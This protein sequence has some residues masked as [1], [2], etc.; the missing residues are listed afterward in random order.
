MSF[1]F[2]PFLIAQ[3]IL[4]AGIRKVLRTRVLIILGVSL[5]CQTYSDLATEHSEVLLEAPYRPGHL[6]NSV[7]LTVDLTKG[8][9]DEAIARKDSI[10]VAYRKFYNFLFN[11]LITDA[12]ISSDPII[13]RSLKSITLEDTQQRS[14]LRLAQEGISIY[15]PHT[16]VDAAPGGLNDWLADLIIAADL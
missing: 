16:A 14:L 8:V 3:L 1:L 2:T 9:V 10:I 12:N 7:L 11:P 13:F 15:S 5:N 6:K 4:C